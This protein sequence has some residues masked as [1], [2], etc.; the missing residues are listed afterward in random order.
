MKLKKIIAAVSA[1]AMVIGC[2]PNVWAE[3]ADVSEEGVSVLPADFEPVTYNVADMHSDGFHIVN[4]YVNDAVIAEV[5]LPEKTKDISICF[6]VNDCDTTFSAW[7]GFA[8]NNWETHAWEESDYFDLLNNKPEFVFNQSGSYE[9]II[10]IGLFLEEDE[11]YFDYDHDYLEDLQVINM[12]FEGDFEESKAT[13]TITDVKAYQKSHTIEECS[14]SN[15][16][17]KPLPD[18]T[19]P[20]EPLPDEP[21]P[22]E[23][24]EPVEGEINGFQYRTNGYG[25]VFIS[26]YTGKDKDIVIPDEIEGIKNIVIDPFA[27]KDLTFIE[28]VKISSSVTEV[29]YHAFAGCDSLKA[30]NV[31]ENNA[32]YA[33]SDGVL[34]D[35]DKTVL[36]CYPAGKSTAYS[37]PEGIEII[38]SYAF[39][40]NTALTSV[41]LPKSMRDIWGKH[42]FKD[43]TSLSSV[44]FLS[45]STTLLIETAEKGGGLVFPNCPNLTIYC[46]ENSATHKHLQNEMVI[47]MY[48][49]QF[50]KPLSYKLLGKEAAVDTENGIVIENPN[51]EGTTLTVT[52]ADGSTDTKITYNI[53]LKDENGNEIQP[54]G[55]VTVKIPLPEGW[56]GAKTIVSRHETDGTYTNMNAVFEN[57]YMVFV[58]E[59]FSEYVL[60]YGELEPDAPAAEN[61]AISDSTTAS[62]ATTTPDDENKPTGL[63]IG[64][65]PAIIAGA[66]VVLSKKRK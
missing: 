25:L 35:K 30:I 57:G 24:A 49:N 14:Y 22:D 3:S 41:V 40:G 4:P 20:D 44:M 54:Q 6:D 28:T 48:T 34:F 51:L 32:N 7:C 19:L 10:P 12:R 47:N 29:S 56:D 53:T 37:V 43:C 8:G 2:M 58:T 27:F 36:Y 26:G 31:D 15:V 61:T 16:I 52:V 17:D 1:A 59:H 38:G 11:Y 9:L 62:D 50:G 33:S 65:V 13:V 55:D 60:S 46:Y 39:A 42:A 5:E 21:F 23:P 18:E 66:A 63:V 45:D 64:I